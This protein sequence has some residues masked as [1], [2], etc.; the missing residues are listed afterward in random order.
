M[1]RAP[2]LAVMPPVGFAPSVRH[3][4]RPDLAAL[5]CAVPCVP[6][7]FRFIERERPR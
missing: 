7:C 5:L 2:V 1:R 3:I 6:W 4:A